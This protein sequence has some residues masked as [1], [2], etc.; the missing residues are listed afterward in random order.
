MWLFR[1]GGNPWRTN[2]FGASLYP[3]KWYRCAANE[4]APPPAI[5]RKA[6]HLH[7][8]TGRLIHYQRFQIPRFLY[9]TA[10]SFDLIYP[11]WRGGQ[12]CWRKGFSHSFSQ[13]FQNAI[14]IKATWTFC[15]EYTHTPPLN[16]KQ[17][18]WGLGRLCFQRFFLQTLMSNSTLL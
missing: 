9:K 6:S 14:N 16:Y 1:S 2:S 3:L 13:I 17:I 11:P 10:T 18:F 12:S 7:T 15:S 5:Y 4:A 8:C